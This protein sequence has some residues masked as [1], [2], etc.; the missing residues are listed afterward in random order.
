MR[1]IIYGVLLFGCLFY[2]LWRGGWPERAAI[3]NLVAMSLLTVVAASPLALRFT[4]VEWDA[5]GIDALCLAIFLAI[6]LRTNL[7]W[8]LW[9]TALQALV[10]LA[11]L[12]KVLDPEMIP[13]GYGFIMAVW[14]YPQIL[15][16]GHAVY[17][18]QRRMKLVRLH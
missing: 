4:T 5:V 1:A 2:A 9:V 8:V 14:S 10:V 6:A 11:H 16:I 15:L 3:I 17:R 7:N 18:R 12:A 13:K